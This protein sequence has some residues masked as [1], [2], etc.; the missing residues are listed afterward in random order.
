MTMAVYKNHPGIKTHSQLEIDPAQ[1]KCPRCRRAPGQ[2]CRSSHGKILAA[3]HR[4]RELLAAETYRSSRRLELLQA[5]RH[6]FAAPFSPRRL[7]QDDCFVRRTP[8]A[9]AGGVQ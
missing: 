3:F 6:P 8:P 9:S 1:V 4:E 2:L 5:H 7:A